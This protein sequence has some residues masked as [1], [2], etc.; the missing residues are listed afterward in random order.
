[1]ASSNKIA[2]HARSFSLPTRSNPLTLTVEEQLCRLRSSELS[3]SLS[4]SS[5]CQNLAGLKDLYESVEDLLQLLVTQ[6]EKSLD[7][8]M[9]GSLVLLDVCGTIRDILSQM[10]QCVQ[11]LQLSIRRRRCGDLDITN[12]ISAYM[13]SR[14]KANKV[15]RRCLRGLKKLNKNCD[16]SVLRE[17]ETTTLAVFESLLSFVSGPKAI[18]KQSSW[19]LVSKLMGTR[20]VTC[21]G[22]EEETSELEKVNITLNSL[23]D[24]KQNKMDPKIA[25]KPL[26]ALEL[27]IQDLEEG[28][29]CVFR[30]LIKNRV[31]LLNILNH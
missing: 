8:V 27:S 11:D 3:T 1:M 28:L 30:S 5:I 17:V 25:Q 13:T 12:E 16:L 10:K 23:M 20:R 26:E 18:T 22:Q 29:V 4:S 9:D 2:Y 15:I 31:S 6:D 19:S 14:K 7:G 21:E 24:Y